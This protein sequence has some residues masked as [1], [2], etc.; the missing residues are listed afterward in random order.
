MHTHTTHTH[1]EG[2]ICLHTCWKQLSNPTTRQSMTCMPLSTTMAFRM[3]GTTR[4][5]SN[6]LL[7]W[8]Q[9]QKVVTLNKH[10]RFLLGGSG[11]WGTPIWIFAAPTEEVLCMQG[12]LLPYLATLWLVPPGMIFWTKHCTPVLVSLYFTF[13]FVWHIGFIPGH[14]LVLETLKAIPN[15]TKSTFPVTISGHVWKTSMP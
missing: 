11:A 5:P 9:E 7:P 8:K 3:G 10:P 4:Q 1:S 14:L 13:M 6:H 15:L 12:Y 2:W